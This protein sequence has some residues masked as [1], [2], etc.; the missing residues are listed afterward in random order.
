MKL[1]IEGEGRMLT[2]LL[3]AALEHSSAILKAVESQVGLQE[4]EA[5][6]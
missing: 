4:G 5:H 1:R 6:H 2:S 3:Q